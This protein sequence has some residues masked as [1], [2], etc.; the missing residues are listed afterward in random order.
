[1]KERLG[2]I[3]AGAGAGLVAGL[4]GA[5]GGL[6]LVPL[7]GWLT[8]LKSQEVFAVSLSI[9]LPVCLVSIAVTA[10][11]SGIDVASALPYLPGSALGGLGRDSV[12]MLNSLPICLVVGTILGFLTGLG[13]GGGSLLMLWL[14]LVLGVSQAEARQINLLFF[15]PSALIS[16]W[17]HKRQGTLNWKTSLP[18]MISGCAAAMLGSWLAASLDTEMLKKPFGILLLIAGARELFYRR[19]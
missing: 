3:I 12:F 17:M 16:C 2:L 11:T 9:I 8:R 14:T 15:L 19:K 5:G 13:I 6:V 18:G 10:L 4:F 1:M 7:L